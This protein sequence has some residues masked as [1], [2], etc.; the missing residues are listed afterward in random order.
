M[1]SLGFPASFYHSI[2]NLINDSRTKAY[3]A[4]NSTMLNAYWEIGRTIVEE[5]Q[6]GED[7]AK[8][9]KFLIKNLSKK[10]NTDFG[11]GFDERNLRYIR[12]FYTAF[13]IRNAVRS[14]LSKILLNCKKPY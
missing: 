4:V 2:R 1:T 12:A 7:R 10:L 8:Y 13:P 6:K 9:G 5:E 14:E 11:K 3:K